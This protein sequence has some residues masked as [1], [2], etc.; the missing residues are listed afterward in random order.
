MI[1]RYDNLISLYKTHEACREE[2]SSKN[3][4]KDLQHWHE[5]ETAERTIGLM[6][7]SE[8]DQYVLPLTG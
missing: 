8:F 3:A 6:Q 2:A 7:D 4:V 5:R 1:S